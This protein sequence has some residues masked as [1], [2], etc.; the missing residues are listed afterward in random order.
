MGFR[1]ADCRAEPDEIREDLAVGTT[2]NFRMR[3]VNATSPGAFRDSV[4]GILT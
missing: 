3:T 1:L 2:I 4:P